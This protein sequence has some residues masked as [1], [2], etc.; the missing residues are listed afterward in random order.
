VGRIHNQHGVELE[1]DRTGLNAARTGKK[2]RGQ[3]LLL[4]NAL[5]HLPG[6]RFEKSFPRRILDQTN[7]R[8]DVGAELHLFARHTGVRGRNRWQAMEE[9]QIAEAGK[10]PGF[11][12]V[13]HEVATGEGTEHRHL[14]DEPIGQKHSF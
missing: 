6:D 7:Q 1:P 3:Q 13:A 2:E 9:R 5:M 11:Q 12:T 14:L 4:A 10:S 8:F